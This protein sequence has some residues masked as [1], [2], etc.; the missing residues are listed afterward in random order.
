MSGKLL[1]ALGRVSRGMRALGDSLAGALKRTPSSPRAAGSLAASLLGGLFLMGLG[2][3]PTTAAAQTC[4]SIPAITL[5]AVND[6]VT[7]D[8]KPCDVYMQTINFGSYWGGIH[9]QN[10][11]A[12]DYPGYG[13]DIGTLEPINSDVS[14]D[15][16]TYRIRGQANAQTAVDFFTVTLIAKDVG[17][18]A[19]DTLTV[20]T[21]PS[22]PAGT[23][24]PCPAT[25]R[26]DITVNLEAVTPPT[27]SAAWNLSTAN[28]GQFRQIQVTVTN[29]GATTLTGVSV[30]AAALPANMVGSSPG[31]T[32]TSG[33]ATYN[34]GTRALSLSGATLNAGAS[35]T[36][37]LSATATAAGS[38]T[39]TTGVVSAA[40]GLTGTTASTGALVVSAVPTVTQITPAAGTTAGSQTVVI[41]GTSFTGVS[42]AGGV[43]FGGTNALGYTV[44]S[45]TQITA[46]S[47]ARA[48]GTVNI[49]VTN[50][51]NTSATGAASQYTY[52]A[53]PVSRFDYRVQRWLQPDDQHPGQSL[54]DG[55]RHPDQLWRRFSD[56]GPG[57][58]GHGRQ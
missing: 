3:A 48:S 54:P 14:T 38:Y 20:W 7:I 31:T 35:C 56:H 50:G 1:S 51:S 15:N 37:T 43:Q 4:T 44:N 53:A 30:A 47:P 41:N 24:S 16:A 22:Y 13:Y 58:F 19:T 5:A 42:G 57:W 49:T 18:P 45:D 33:T 11:N 39:Y 10:E 28:V 36:V 26:V 17:A 27:I 34:G 21:C 46:T 9:S 32:C 29:P 40:G 12:F 6:S 8:A 23:D 25:R 55:W 52:V 2:L